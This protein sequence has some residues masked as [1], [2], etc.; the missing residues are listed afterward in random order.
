MST[1]AFRAGV[2]AADTQS[3]F[4][5]SPHLGAVKLFRTRDFVLGF[6]GRYPLSF[7]VVEW[8]RDVEAGLIGTLLD[9]LTH[10]AS[11]MPHDADE[12]AALEMLAYRSDGRLFH[13][14]SCGEFVPLSVEFAAIGCGA[15]FAIGAMAMG[16]TAAQ[17]VRVA[18]QHDIYTGG[19]VQIMRH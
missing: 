17:S 5:D 6:V 9:P 14:F 12:P 8:F 19:P 1:V 13:G 18:R 15:R 16:A 2:M 7:H 11:T 4:R 10:D 3:T